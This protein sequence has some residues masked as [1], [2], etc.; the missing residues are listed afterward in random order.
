MRNTTGAST[1]DADREHEQAASALT[2]SEQ[3]IWVGQKLDP[4]APLYNMALSIEIATALDVSAFTQ[5]FQQLVDATDALRTS[6]VEIEGGP[7]RVVRPRVPA[8]VEVLTLPEGAVDDA[9]VTALLEA[10]TRR[11]FALDGV[12]FDCC[13]IERRPDRFLWYLNQH[14]LITDAGSVGVL[15]RRMSALYETV[16][17]RA[18]HRL[19]GGHAEVAE[20]EQRS[21]PQFQ[22]YAEHERMLRGSTRL[23]RALAYWDAMPG[24]RNVPLYGDSR[25][26]SGRTRRVRVRL[27]RDRVAALDAVVRAAPFRALT[28]EQSRFQLFATVLLAWLHRI[29]DEDAV[30]VGTPWHNRSSATFR[31]TAGLFI[32]LFPLRVA[33]DDGETFASLGAK[34]AAA[35]LDTMRHVV[36]G[37]SASPGAR[38]FGAVLN[39]I[40]AKLGDFAGTPVRADWIHSGY[41][42]RDHRVR[43]QVHEFGLAGDP[44][45]DFDL[46]EAAFGAM[47]REWAV[48]HFLALFDALVADS[49]RPIATVRLTDWDEEAT[50]APR[51]RATP[52]P[53][54][55][56]ALVEESVRAA[57]GT[58]AVRDG[59]RCVTYAELDAASRQ[60]ARLLRDAGVG[61][62]TVVG[63]AIDRSS[64]MVVAMLAVLTAGGA[65][66]PLDLAYP[67]ERLTL[68]V[69][70]AGVGLVITTSERAERVRA[71]GA[72]P[73]IPSE[74]RN[75]CRP[76]RESLY[77]HPCDSSTAAPAGASARNDIRPDALAYVLYTSGSTG[78]PKG[79]EITHGAFADYVAWAARRYTDGERLL[80]P[81]FTS[82]AFD[83]TLTSIFVPLA[84]AGTIVVYP[85]EIGASGLVVRRVFEDNQ[86]DVVKLT[87]S[88]LALLR[89]LDLSRAR[90]RRLIVGGEDLTRAAALAAHDAL[91]GRAEILNEY[92]PTEATVACMLHRFDPATDTRGSVPIG[93]P[94]DNARVHVLDAFGAPAPR[95]VAGEIY[96]GGP[97]VARGYR[98]RPD[99]TARAFVPDPLD[100]SGRC[101]RTGDVGRWLPN[102]VMEFLGRRDDQVKVR[103]VRIELGEIEAMLAAHPAIEAC[104]AHVATASRAEHTARCAQCGL[105][106]VHPEA[107]LD[108]E[109]V[110]A[111]CRRFAHERERVARY[112]GTLDD[113]RAMLADAASESTGAHDCIMLYSGGKDSTYALS[114]IV[115]LGARPLVFLFD[116]G[117]ISGQAKDNARR[118]ADALG[119]ELVIGETPAMPAIFADSLARFSNVCNGCFKTIYTLAMHLAEARGIRY[120]VTG[121]SR[122]QIFETRLAD[123]YR[124]GVYDPKTVDRVILEARKA[125]HRMDDAV[126]RELD[127]RIFETDA[128]LDRVRFIDFFR[129]CDASLEEILEHLDRRTPWIRPTDTGRST[130]CL[131]NQAGIYVHQTERG[132][133]SYAM[134]YSWDVRLGH[135]RRDAAVAELDDRLD[136]PAIRDMLDR[137][138]Y[139][140]RAV[141]PDERRL[142]A[143][144][145]SRREIAAAELRQFLERSLPRDVV[146]SAFVRLDRL[147]LAPSGKVDR[148][149][150]PQPDALRPTLAAAFV[151]PRT[152]V[153]R[154]LAE[155]W[156][157][158]LDV[159]PIGAHDDFFELGGD[160]MHCI[161]IVA[162]ARTQ[163]V[164]FAPRDVFAHP[165]VAGLATVASRLDEPAPPRAAT[166]SDAELAELLD[167]FG[168]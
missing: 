167:E 42:D 112:F 48:R 99:L 41:G 165:T 33:I 18:H 22:A 44:V 8:E 58:V 29:S 59:D 156:G 77:Q 128:V 65:F 124:R 56:L 133:H 104:V 125:Y 139:R 68:L 54:S 123:L 64:A 70:D 1:R 62:E 25:V 86:A 145:T 47:E 140:P 74:A 122:G 17:R 83:L 85:D 107:R 50:F 153:E 131:I 157:D 13:L 160:S 135:K 43:L 102:G 96:I 136:P 162:A 31:D 66:V 168:A 80:W 103:G 53:V 151:A 149:A 49:H 9:A 92:G 7:R 2:A 95:G 114:R 115:E 40:T 118:V 6:F 106:A 121:L 110:C 126:A 117:F 150:L 97:R 87:P 60:L 11:V 143:Y 161:Q 10:R 116:N 79:V 72:V 89:D 88:H 45:L 155:V 130:N 141:A 158:V 127:V 108:D 111:V 134:P 138:G 55:V 91:G 81:L 12:L 69:A 98:R 105:E 129:Y 24:S 37:A 113:L 51:G 4:A 159:R 119:L 63:I 148:A 146:P 163:G 28:P 14:H 84:T 76:D 46:D 132:F 90:V 78:Q 166:A 23:S 73:V 34:V 101:Y 93:R 142:V 30:A 152:D 137:V 94:A 5:A 38:A 71:W 57:P 67:D 147:P 15:H 39:Y 27:G 35:T 3:L 120:I 75:R 100:P 82:P 52:S 154:I 61:P 164:V 16:L 21:L 20:G 32:E 19:N 109:G 36:P 26:G 144:Y